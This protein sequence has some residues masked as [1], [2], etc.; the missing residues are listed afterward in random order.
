VIL[1]RSNPAGAGKGKSLERRGR[2]LSAE[3]GRAMSP[4]VDALADQAI[5]KVICFVDY[6]WWKRCL[7]LPDF[8][9]RL[10]G[11][12]KPLAHIRG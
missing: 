10:D 12:W 11:L 2:R 6:A 7:E 4:L 3:P 9:D 1:S 8:G 5:V